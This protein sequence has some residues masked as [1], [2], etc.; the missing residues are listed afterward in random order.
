[1]V[2]LRS[3]GSHTR[4]EEKFSEARPTPWLSAYKEMGA[5]VLQPQ[6]TWGSANNMDKL[7]NGFFPR[8]QGEK[9]SSAK[10]LILAL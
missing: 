6:G 8:A 3:E 2:T 1:M 4:T 7:G 9:C 10:T 5:L